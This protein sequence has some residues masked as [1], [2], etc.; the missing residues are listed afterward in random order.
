MTTFEAIILGVVQGLTEF[1][2]VSS[3][4][5]L[6]FVQNLMPSFRQVG[7]LFDVMLHVGTL[8]ALV[9]FY[10]KLLG[11]AARGLVSP[12][13]PERDRSLKLLLLV[14]VATIPT[15]IVGLFLKKTVESAFT[16]LRAV[17]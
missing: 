1:L 4:G 13:R 9:V 5:H 7:V 15:A 8:I 12:D 3:S 11:N 14:V 10:R 2:P 17:G 16:D 6:A